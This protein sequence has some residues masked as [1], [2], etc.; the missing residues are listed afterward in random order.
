MSWRGRIAGL[1]SVVAI[2]VALCSGTMRSQP[3]GRLKLPAEFTEYRKWSQL[4]KSPHAV[5]LELWLRCVA[6]TADD[7]AAERKKYGPHAERYIQVYANEGVVAALARPTRKPF[8]AGAV[9]AK[10]KLSRSDNGAPEGV[11]FMVKRGKPLFPDTAGWEFLYFP[12]SGDPRRTHTACALCHRAAA[13]RDYV[14]G[15]YPRE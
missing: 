7:W 12:P 10:E 4:L 15:K 5:S 1:F 11:A 6:P 9:I 3:D 13:S 8:P 14:F 2:G